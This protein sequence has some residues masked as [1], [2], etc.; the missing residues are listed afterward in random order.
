LS[1]LAYILKCGYGLQG[2]SENESR[3]EN[4]TVPSGGKRYPLEI[5]VFLFKEID[6]CKEGIYHYGILRHTLE[7][8][9]I[10]RFSKSDIMALTPFEWLQGANG[11]ICITS[12]FGRAVNKYGSRSYRYILIEAGHAAQNMLL[13]GTENAIDMIPIAGV[14]ESEI[15]R[16]LGLSSLQERAVYALFL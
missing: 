6:G 13:A 1:N 16:I 2:N 8:I 12:V 15:E 14:N 11:M 10:K 4:R 7:P 9:L 3:R 5:Y